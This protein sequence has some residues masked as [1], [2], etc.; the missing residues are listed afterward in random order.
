MNS[1]H[2]ASRLFLTIAALGL[3][4][5]LSSCRSKPEQAADAEPVTPVQTAT[6]TQQ[7]IDRIVTADAVLYP[8]RQ[9]GITPKITAPIRRFL[10]N[11]G[12]HVRQGQLLAELEDRDLVA[13]AN[14]SKALYDQAQSQFAT[15]TR[16][17]LPEDMTKARA[18]VQSARQSL[19]AAQKLYDNRVTL[20]REGALAQK[21]ADDAKVALAQA[22]SLYDTANR[23]LQSLRSVS[24]NEQV[25]S[26]QSQV[27]AAKARY[28]SMEAQVS[29]AQV[30]SPIKGVVADRPSYVGEMASA[31]TP[32]IT[33]VDNSE[34]I[35]RAN[36]PASEL[37][38]VNVGDKATITAA[39]GSIAGKVTV[40]S[41][42]VDPSS[43]T[44]EIWVMA[45]NTGEK[46]KPGETA[47]VSLHAETI[48]NAIVVPVAAVL[49]S[50]EGGS[51]VM[52]VKPD[53]TVEERKIETGV[54][55][56]DDIQI[57]SGL[58]PGEAVVTVGGIGLDD[59]AKV[60]VENADKHE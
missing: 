23:H 10:V 50:D 32:V 18:D 46:L 26:A 47:K 25:K 35:A 28:A 9:S 17:T 15:V 16:G 54:R 4:A 8:M 20:V 34:I 33:I 30:V 58:K 39:E 19:E 59:K 56:G 11:R 53:S 5:L 6:A 57:T 21:L 44:A 38:S 41:P 14:E 3:P 52:V 48:P 22:Q 43:T 55:Q 37:R 24:R 40:V 2:P 31:G 51:K 42:T 49:S 13:N 36:V 27:D 7:S 1:R 45:V 29:Y 12:D 60:K